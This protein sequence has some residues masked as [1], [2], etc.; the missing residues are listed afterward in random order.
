[1]NVS[2][3]CLLSRASLWIH[4]YEPLRMNRWTYALAWGGVVIL[5]L[6]S[7]RF[8]TQLPWFVSTYAGDTLWGSAVYLLAALLRP[9]WSPVCKGWYALGFAVAIELSQLYHAEWIDSLRHTSPFGLVLGYDFIWSDLLCYL[10][11]I[12]AAMGIDW[13]YSR[14]RLRLGKSRYI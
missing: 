12:L 13:W 1:M 8:A 9:T 2:S 10:T 14:C 11:G 6:A 5:G 4:G 3:E 7:R